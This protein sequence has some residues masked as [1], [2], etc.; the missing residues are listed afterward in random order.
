MCLWTSTSYALA[1]FTT[2]CP[3]VGQ[4]VRSR[5]SQL[6]FSVVDAV[7][8][9]P[10]ILAEYCRPVGRCRRQRQP[11][12]RVCVD[13]RL[14]GLPTLGL[15]TLFYAKA[16]CMRAVCGCRGRCSAIDKCTDSAIETTEK[17]AVI[18][19]GRARLL[20]GYVPG[21]NAELAWTLPNAACAHAPRCRRAR[22][23][24]RSC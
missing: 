7:L 2:S 8:T 15:Q 19:E 13:A 22:E 5:H 20:G 4:C 18:G 6:P 12:R 1:Y 11:H 23:H 3:Y 10:K 14:N 9:Q 17:E 16:Q 24:T 21:E